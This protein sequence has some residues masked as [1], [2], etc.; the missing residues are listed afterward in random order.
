MCTFTSLE[1]YLAKR[2]AHNI[3]VVANMTNPVETSIRQKLTDELDPE[4]LEIIN[5]SYMHNV[6][7]G[8]ETHFKVTVVSNKFKDVPLI[9]VSACKSTV[10]IAIASIKSITVSFQLCGNWNL[11]NAIVIYNHSLT[12]LLIC[13][14]S[15][16]IFNFTIH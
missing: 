11:A 1:V 5:E 10:M 6:P 16:T 4:H 8:S 13:V 9:K 2:L 7:K 3:A 15:N 12:F 14:N